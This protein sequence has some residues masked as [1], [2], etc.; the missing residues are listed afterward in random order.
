MTVTMRVFVVLM[1]LGLTGTPARAESAPMTGADSMCRLWDGETR[2]VNALWVENPPERKMGEGRNAVVIAD[3]K[4]PGIITMIHF[5]LPATLKLDRSVT[6]RM[7]WDGESR[8]SVECPLV[9]F[10]CDPNGA[11]E[12]V[13]SALV[14]KKRGWNAY[15]LMPFARSARIEVLA[16]NPRYPTQW[17]TSPCYSCV[18]YREVKKLP[19]R[20]GY[21]HAQWRQETL[22]LGK[23]DYEVFTAQGRGHFIGWNMTIRGAG[24]SPGYPVDENEKFFVD[25]ENEARVEWQGLEDSFGFSWGFPEAANSF[26]YTGYQPY[27]NGGA[28]AY[29]FCVNDRI[30]FK[31]SL[32]MTVGFGKNEDRSF[33][34]IFSKPD[35]PLQFSSVAYWYQIE[36]HAPFPPLPPVRERQPAPAAE[37]KPADAAKYDAAGETVVLN[38]GKTGGDI[39]YLKEGWDFVLTRGFL[40][41]GWPTA[42]NHCWADKT[43][44]E[45]DIT[46]PKGA[47]GT[48]KLFILDGDN[49][50]GGRRQSIAVAGRKISEY[51][52]FQKGQ[53][54]ETPIGAGDTGE[55]RIPVVITNLKPEA[56][57]VVSLI[58]FVAGGPTH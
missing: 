15:F 6:L 55:G 36:P 14:N 47:S 19:K 8:P 44:L 53:W 57:A 22:L 1:G 34:E 12:R 20:L 17:D 3:L 27:L 18:M 10:F 4:G 26:P 21:F 7:Y 38:C 35:N 24:A 25:G 43:S 11:L 13:D 9:D 46:C 45:F 56:N 42:I 51:Q 37:P 58:R 31:K 28:A 2:M 32:R 50:Q 16:E 40:Y 54:I 33:F 5:A 29:R 23:S 49:F 41:A 30:G 52:N 48:L 39:A